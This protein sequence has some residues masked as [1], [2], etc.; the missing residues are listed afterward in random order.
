MLL[1]LRMTLLAALTA[2]L[3]VAA[4]AFAGDNGE[5]LAG[6]TDDKLVTFFALGVTLFFAVVALIGTILQGRAE[7]RKDA[8]KAAAGAVPDFFGSAKRGESSIT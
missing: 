7:R 6:E 5:G 8:K 4:P 3:L 1:R 2:A